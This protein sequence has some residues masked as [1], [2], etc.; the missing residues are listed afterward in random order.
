MYFFKYS[1]CYVCP[2]HRI[3][4]V[5]NPYRLSDLQ[6]FR[7]SVSSQLGTF[8]GP[9]TCFPSRPDIQVGIR[10]S[11]VNYLVGGY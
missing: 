1:K 5:E 6:G 7:V 11:Y 2:V 9:Y 8:H 4:I 10:T 3:E